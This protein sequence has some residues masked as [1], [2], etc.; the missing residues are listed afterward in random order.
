MARMKKHSKS[1]PFIIIFAV[2]I[3]LFIGY[4]VL[5]ASNQSDTGSD[6]PDEGVEMIIDRDPSEIVSL[7]YKLYGEDELSFTYNSAVAA[8]KLTDDSSFPLDQEKVGYMAAAISSIGVFRTLET[9]D[10]GAFG[11][12]APTAEIS[13]RYSDGDKYHYAIGDENPT[14]GYLYF[15]DIDAGKVYTISSG[16]LPYFYYELKDLFVYDTLPDDIQKEYITSVTLKIG[17]EKKELTDSESIEK[18]FDLFN[19]L[20]PSDYFD[21]KADEA[22]KT[23]YGM[24]AAVLTINYK[25]AVEATDTSGATM[26]TRVATSYSITFGNKSAEQLGSVM[27]PYSIGTSAVIYGTPEQYSIL[28][29]LLVAFGMSFK[30]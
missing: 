7:S 11:F 9:G 25:R 6:T 20:E 13:V 16:L 18:V 21:W 26:S 2:V 22:T 10:T 1:L 12:S 5:I 14:T 30:E 19:R 23:K 3:A 15:K 8:W 17:D 4:K 28:N 29:D 24:G 27:T